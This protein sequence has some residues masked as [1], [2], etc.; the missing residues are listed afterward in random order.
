MK[1]Y[2]NKKRIYVNIPI[3][4]KESE[5]GGMLSVT[6]IRKTVI[7][8]RVVTPMETFSPNEIK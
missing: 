2:N 7:E 4:G 8:R 3:N 5:L 1:E 6:N